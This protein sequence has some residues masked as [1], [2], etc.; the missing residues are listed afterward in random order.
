M[1]TRLFFKR[2]FVFVKH[3]G[4]ARAGAL[5]AYGAYLCSLFQLSVGFWVFLGRTRSGMG[6]LGTMRTPIA[7]ATV[8]F[9]PPCA[10]PL[11]L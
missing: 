3:F 2:N 5:D 7:L 4:V 10:G 11:L 8:I 9:A 6:M 1:K